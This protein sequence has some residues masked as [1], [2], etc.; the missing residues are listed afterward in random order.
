[1]TTIVTPYLETHGLGM[2]FEQAL[3]LE[4]IDLSVGAGQFILL[5]G[6]NGGGK[7]TLVRLLLGLL[8]PTQGRIE[9]MPRL[10]M[11]YLPQYQRMDRQFPI[12]VEEVVQSGLLS[13]TG[14]LGR[15]SAEQREHVR[16]VLHE[17]A[18]AE[19]KDRPISALSGGQ[20]QRVLFARAVVARP[21]VLFLDEPDTYLDHTFQTQLT[22]LLEHYAKRCTIVLVTH[23]PHGIERLATDIYRVDTQLY[24]V[25][26]IDLCHHHSGHVEGRC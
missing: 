8:Q 18:L 13:R 6:P 20:L 23:N 22:H 5:T 14:L 24:G 10:L 15:L 12:S 3:A 16:A 9:R 4:S 17:L 11:G 25:D 19:L 21:H 1:M 26:R 2:R 7:T